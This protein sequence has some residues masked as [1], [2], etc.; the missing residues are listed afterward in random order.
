MLLQETDAPKRQ[1]VT[2]DTVASASEPGRG[3][4]PLSPP[5]ISTLQQS[6]PM[7][8]FNDSELSGKSIDGIY[9]EP[10]TISDLFSM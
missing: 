3:S 8:S 5:V 2:N 10:E 6:I 9:L 4:K 1:L 7:R